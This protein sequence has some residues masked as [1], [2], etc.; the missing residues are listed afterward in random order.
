MARPGRTDIASESKCRMELSLPGGIA[1]DIELDDGP[2]ARVEHGRNLAARRGRCAPSHL[3]VG[4][5][6]SPVTCQLC[7]GALLHRTNQ[8]A[9][10][11]CRPD[12]CIQPS[13]MPLAS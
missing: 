12:P 5:C 10:T 1:T 4:L 3:D 6:F 2:T 13:P 8:S 11:V 7:H 9:V